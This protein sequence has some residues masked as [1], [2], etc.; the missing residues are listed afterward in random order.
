MAP[1]HRHDCFDF[2][3]HHGAAQNS[4]G[5]L[6]VDDGRYT[7][8]FIDVSCCTKTGDGSGF[9]GSGRRKGKRLTAAENRSCKRA[10]S[11]QKSSAIPVVFERHRTMPPSLRRAPRQ[12]CS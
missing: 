2:R 4:H 7:Q 10:E 6:A 12:Q 9:A 8:F 5:S 1:R 11:A 3:T